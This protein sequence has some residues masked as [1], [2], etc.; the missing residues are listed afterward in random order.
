MFI[1]MN[2]LKVLLI[3][4]LFASCKSPSLNEPSNPPKKKNILERTKWKNSGTEGFDTDVILDFY[5]DK[6]VQE[7]LI[8]GSNGK[9]IK[10]REGTYKIKGRYLNIK[11]SGALSDKESGQVE[12]KS[13]N[14]TD[15]YLRSKKYHKISSY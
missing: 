15:K 14:L 5:T 12:E 2:I 3:L 13:M 10:S 7:Y 4:L 11:W 9:E 1:K 6:N 8:V